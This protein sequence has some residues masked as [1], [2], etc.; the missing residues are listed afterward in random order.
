MQAQKAGFIRPA[1]LFAIERPWNFSQL[2]KY[3]FY[4]VG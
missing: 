4:E 3:R 2:S 1:F